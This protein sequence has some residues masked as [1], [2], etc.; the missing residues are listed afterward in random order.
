MKVLWQI[1][2]VLLPLLSFAQYSTYNFSHVDERV[3][4]IPSATPDSLARALTTP[5]TKDVEKVRSIF[6]W[7]TENISY[8][9][10]NQYLTAHVSSSKL[11]EGEAEDTGALKPLDER[12]AD[13]VLERRVAV[14]DGYARLFKT[15]CNYA[16]IRCELISGYANGGFGGRKFNSNH[17][18]NAVYIDSSWHLLDVT[19]ASGG[20]SY[21]GDR[22]IKNFNDTYFLTPPQEFIRDHYPDELQ[23]TLLPN[24]PVITEFNRAPFSTAAFYKNYITSYK[25]SRGIIEASVGDTLLF[26]L[27]TDAEK[28]TVFIVDT[29]F[30]DSA[31][32]SRPIWR[33][34]A[35]P[36]INGKKLTCMYTVTSEKVDWINI[37]LNDEVVMRYK[38]NVRRNIAVLN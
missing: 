36:T 12:V 25:P 1:L 18:W 9:V 37:V 10:K 7:I 34:V 6:R 3:Y 14:C 24:P 27:E 5:Y 38:L 4:S 35:K 20:T 2:L 33:E 22:F 28:K 31:I 15:L 17:K 16:G 26:E 8:R 19:W 11:K 32:I 30:V 13:I 21:L 23:W 29:S